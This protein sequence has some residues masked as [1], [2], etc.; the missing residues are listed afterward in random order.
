MLNRQGIRPAWARVRELCIPVCDRE[1]HSP[2]PGKFWKV[3]SGFVSRI[4]NSSTW[5]SRGVK[6]SLRQFHIGR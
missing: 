3:G 5:S 4:K 2:Q 1:D 6:I